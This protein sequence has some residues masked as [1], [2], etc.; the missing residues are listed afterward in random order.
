[1]TCLMF[2]LEGLS[3]REF[4]VNYF[5]NSDGMLGNKCKTNLSVIL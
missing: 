3:F 5:T 2:K 4:E 1:M